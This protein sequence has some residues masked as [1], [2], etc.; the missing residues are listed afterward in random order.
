MLTKLGTHLVLILSLVALATA[1]QAERT[2]Y[3]VPQAEVPGRRIELSALKGAVL[4]VPPEAENRSRL[5]LIVH[6]LG[7]RCFIK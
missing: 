6:F 3:R 5:P 4:F 7:A 1:Q 2:R